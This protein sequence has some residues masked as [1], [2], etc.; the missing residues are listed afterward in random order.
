[1][2]VKILVVEDEVIIGMDIRKTLKK[3]GYEVPSVVSAGDKAIEGAAE[4][5]PDLVL[6]DIMLRGKIDGIEAAEQIRRRFNIP[7]V[8]LTAHTDLSTLERAKKAEPFGY[9]VKPFEER[10]LH[11]TVEI[12]MARHRS[13]SEV[14]KALQKEKEL[15][16]LKSRFVSM[17]S[18]EF[19]TPLSTILFSAGLLETYGPKWPEEKKVTH[20]HRIQTAVRQMTGLLEDILVIGKAEAGKLEFNPAPLDLEQFCRE[21]AEEIQITDVNKH[22]INFVSQGRLNDAIMDDKM[23]RHILSN[24]L[25]NAIKYSPEGSTVDFEL[26]ALEHRGEEQS[27]A[28]VFRIQDRGIGIPPEDVDRLFETFYRATNVGTIQGTGLGLAIVKRAVDL[29]GGEIDV[30]S[31]VGAGTR[32]TV[33]LPYTNFGF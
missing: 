16:E 29:H 18:H 1:M 5:Q 7:V 4:M 25:S 22:C 3:L 13:E 10:E 17:V 31:E 19:R 11:T 6:M 14:R 12:A 24:L 26:T 28:V 23:L 21:I 30:K 32:F 27:P 2:N 15:N 20:L 9:I 33:T 8:F